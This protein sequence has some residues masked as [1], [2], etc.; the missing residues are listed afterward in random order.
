MKMKNK[1]I[2]EKRKEA[3]FFQYSLI[4]VLYANDCA[5]NMA[6]NVCNA[7]KYTNYKSKIFKTLCNAIRKDSER[8][9][10][11]FNDVFK[12]NIEFISEF[13]VMCD[14]RCDEMTDN[15]VEKIREA[16]SKA[17]VENSEF[18]AMLETCRFLVGYSCKMNDKVIEKAGKRF[19]SVKVI[20]SWNITRIKNM[21]EELSDY[22]F[23]VIPK[24]I[25]L[26]LDKVDG[27]S[28]T[29]NDW[30][31]NIFSFEKYEEKINSIK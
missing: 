11:V 6:L 25:K 14:E 28:D 8:Y 9:F 21:I 30:I 5:L 18:I 19:K 22:V 26:D 3:E 31:K 27:L 10:S 4:T 24:E 2:D 20:E 7:L 15:V 13:N 12:E 29:I 23:S 1:D 17:G 16:L